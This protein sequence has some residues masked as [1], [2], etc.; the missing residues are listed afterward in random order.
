M[1]KTLLATFAVLA[2]VISTA[3][4]A[5][6]AKE[7]KRPPKNQPAAVE[8]PTAIVSLGDSYISGEAGRWDGN[9]ANNDGS[10]DG[11]DRAWNG[12]GYDV[13]S[14]YVDGT[15]AD[16]C[17]RSDV[18]DIHSTGLAVDAS[19]NLACSGAQ[20]ANVVSGGTAQNGHAPQVDQLAAVAATH[21][22][23]MVVLSIGGNDL[24]F[25]DIIISCTVDWFTSPWWWKNTCAGDEQPNVDA[26]MPAAMAGVATSIDDIRSTLSAA[27]QA[28]G[29]YRLVLRSYPSPIPRASE[30]RYPESG[31]SR[32]DDGGCPFWNSDSNWARD[33]LVPQIS[34]NLRAVAAN[35]GVE[36]LDM[37]DALQGRE[38]CSTQR[39]HVTSSPNGAQHEWVR[40]LNTGYN[41]GEAQESLHPNAFGQRAAGRCLGLLAGLPS[42]D[43]TCTPTAGGSPN[44]MAVSPI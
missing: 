16:G 14:V 12:S 26:R 4:P 35:K 43:Y 41:Q 31:W 30:N 29:S 2:L 36:F 10:R 40:W 20:T 42:G 25:A 21:D 39:S 37:Q 1:R 7:R 18:A 19:I 22:V 44:D 34:D 9:S 32:W 15:D 17:H 24:G 6:A 11:T 38:V 13:G 8:L 33:S 27:G 23:E 3:G 28:P 5:T